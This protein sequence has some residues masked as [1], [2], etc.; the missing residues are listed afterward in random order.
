MLAKDIKTGN[1][2]TILKMHQLQKKILKHFTCNIIQTFKGWD[3]LKFQKILFY[4]ISYKNS[5][6]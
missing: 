4:D 6:G 1:K 2:K 5:A 3:I